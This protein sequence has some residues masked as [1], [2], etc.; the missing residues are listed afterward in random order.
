MP[1]ICF[2]ISF[3]SNFTNAIGFESPAM[4]YGHGIVETLF[5]TWTNIA[6]V[7]RGKVITSV[8]PFSFLIKDILKGYKT[9]TSLLA[10]TYC[11]QS[12]PTLT[13]KFIRVCFVHNINANIYKTDQCDTNF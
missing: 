9:L 7:A 6:Q 4:S 13:C 8:F 10:I 12:K 5:V 2:S 1:L 11:C 3:V